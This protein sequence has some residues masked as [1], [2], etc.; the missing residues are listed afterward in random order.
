MGIAMIASLLALMTGVHSEVWEG[1]C[2]I[3]MKSMGLED[4]I[5]A[6]RTSYIKVNDVTYFNAAPA[7][8][9]QNTGFNLVTVDPATCAVSNPTTFD[10]YLSS[11][12]SGQLE[13]YINAVPV[14][15][16]IL[17]VT[18]NSAELRLYDT[19]K[20]A[21]SSIGV[22]VTGLS[23]RSKLLF[24]AVKGSTKTPVVLRAAK[25]G[26]ALRYSYSFGKGSA[27]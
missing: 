16:V 20:H 9:L 17:G 11:T 7:D 14:G 27:S 5:V 4:A 3:E 21:L 12:A 23:F 24:S 15:S 19:A 1:P 8:Y 13:T 6:E 2:K 10:T 18:S 22:D 25:G 26:E